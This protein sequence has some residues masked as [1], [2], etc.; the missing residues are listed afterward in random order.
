MRLRRETLR[1]RFSNDGSERGSLGSI[2]PKLAGLAPYSELQIDFKIT[3]KGITANFNDL[4][5]SVLS[6]AEAPLR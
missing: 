3:N 4:E 1:C 2:G 5:A 6:R